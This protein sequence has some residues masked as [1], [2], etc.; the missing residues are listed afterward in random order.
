MAQCG[1]QD[2]LIGLKQGN[3]RFL[4]GNARSRV[5]PRKLLADLATAISAPA[6][7]DPP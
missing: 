1:A 2:A 5:F 4:S 3:Q 6:S 7:A